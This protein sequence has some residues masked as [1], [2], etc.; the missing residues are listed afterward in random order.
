MSAVID[1]AP[2]SAAVCPSRQSAPPVARVARDAWEAAA[3]RAA[4][5]ARAVSRGGQLFVWPSRSSG[6]LVAHSLEQRGHGRA[7][8]EVAGGVVLKIAGADGGEDAVVPEALQH[9]ELTRA[10]VG[11]GPVLHRARRAGAGRLF[12]EGAVVGVRKA[13]AIV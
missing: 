12:A 1:V 7:V 9:L 3:T 4:R 11:L 13:V 10:R 5:C 2:T 6:Q 8:A